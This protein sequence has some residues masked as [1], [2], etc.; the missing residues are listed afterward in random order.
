MHVGSLLLPL[1]LACMIQCNKYGKIYAASS[2]MLCKCVPIVCV[3][4]ETDKLT[5]EHVTKWIGRWT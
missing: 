1:S 4:P 5:W 3:Y 2:A